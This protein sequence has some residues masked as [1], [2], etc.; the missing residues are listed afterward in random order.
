[1][2]EMGE[3]LRAT[4]DALMRDLDVLATLEDQKRLMT[5]GDPGLVDLA[6]RIESIAE[7]ILGQSARQRELSQRV[8]ALS[9]AG[10]PAAP[11]QSIEETARALPT[12][13]AEWRDAERRLAAADSGSAEETET[14]LLVERLR[15]EYGRAHDEW[16]RNLRS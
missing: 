10:S 2:T 14:R 1:M 9:S 12:I 11:T 7:R 6:E 8:E 4:S 16:R 15:S 13:L 3:A 5:P